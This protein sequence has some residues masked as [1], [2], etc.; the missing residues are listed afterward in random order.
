MI[1]C[2]CD[3]CHHINHINRV[4]FCSF[5]VA[6]KFNE[7]VIFSSSDY[8]II[9]GISPEE[10]AILENVYLELI[11]F[12]IYVDSSHY[13]QCSKYIEKEICRNNKETILYI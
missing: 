12:D 6:I 5:L 4:L 1:I 9:G 10:L 7:D 2:Y 3:Y 8:A 13:Y 11:E